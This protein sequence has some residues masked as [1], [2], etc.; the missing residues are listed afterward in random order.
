MEAENEKRAEEIQNKSSK[1]WFGQILFL[2]LC[3]IAAI[4]LTIAVFTDMNSTVIS[5]SAAIIGIGLVGNMIFAFIRAYLS[6][7]K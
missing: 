3:V 6:R 7:S 5:I 4:P 2:T 1:A